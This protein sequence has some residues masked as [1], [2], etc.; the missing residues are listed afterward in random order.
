M[1][2]RFEFNAVF[3]NSKQRHVIQIVGLGYPTF[4]FSNSTN[5]KHQKSNVKFRLIIILA[6][7]F[8]N[9]NN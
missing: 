5:I 6:L 8:N 3:L 2:I 1:I 7:V 9:N 4:N